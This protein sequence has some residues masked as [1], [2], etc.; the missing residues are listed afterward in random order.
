MI[1]YYNTGYNFI[2]V[3]GQEKYFIPNLTKLETFTFFIDSVRYSADKKQQDRYF[4]SARAQNILSLPFGYHPE[5]VPGGMNLFLYFF[6]QSNYPAQLTGWFTLNSVTLNQDLMSPVTNANLGVPIVTGAGLLTA[7]NLVINGVDLA[8]TYA[9]PTALLNQINTGVIPFVR[10]TFAQNQFSLVSVSGATINIVTNGTESLINNFTFSNFNT[11]NGPLN[12][13]FSAMQ[14]D[15]FY[16]NYLQYR[17]ADRLCTAYNFITPPG[18]KE[19]LLKY[20]QMISKKSSPQDLSINKIS[21]LTNQTGINYA[22]V[23][24]GHGWTT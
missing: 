17:L 18:V 24:L 19:Q 14:L 11:T 13:N 2:L 9:T 21:T 5:R 6:P 22:Q 12:Q 23:N 15:Q 7:G 16:I 1:P 8:G 3:P 4:G 10:A 20:L